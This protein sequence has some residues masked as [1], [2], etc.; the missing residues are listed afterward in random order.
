[1]SACCEWCGG[2]F[3][4]ANTRRKFCSDACSAASRMAR[5]RARDRSDHDAVLAAFSEWCWLAARRARN[6]DQK[7]RAF[8]ALLRVARDPEPFLPVAADLGL[9]VSEVAA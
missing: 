1:M 2:E 6:E 5:K 8:E 3:A 9:F 7:L 4:S